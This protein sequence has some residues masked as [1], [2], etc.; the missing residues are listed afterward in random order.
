MIHVCRFTICNCY[1]HNFTSNTF[2]EKTILRYMISKIAIVLRFDIDI[3]LDM[4]ISK[5][6]QNVYIIKSV[7]CHILI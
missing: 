4:K 3:Q 2:S 5:N 6:C 1:M 7:L